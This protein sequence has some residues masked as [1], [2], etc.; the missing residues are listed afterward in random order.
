MITRVGGTTVDPAY[1]RE[2]CE[3]LDL[4]PRRPM[5]TY[6]RGNKQKVG[7][8]AAFMR[9]PDL[10]ILDE[11]T[12]GLDPLIQ[13]HV[14]DLVREARAEGRTV[15]LSSH[16]LPEVQAVCDR[17]G[18]IR[19]G[20][21]VATERVDQLIHSRLQRL[22]IRFERLP[23]SGALDLPGVTEVSRVG[24]QVSLEIRENLN[25]FLAQAVA[26]GVLEIETAQVSLEEVFMAYYDKNGEGI[27]DQP[28]AA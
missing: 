20:Q 22:N 11:P 14:L 23:P 12:T 25:Q 26:F 1:R 28:V 24:D 6:S 18:I 3:R 8:I 7:L 16:V 9:R 17:A 19:A 21:I 27:Y 2:R 15:F 5:R 4:D 10:L 13:Q